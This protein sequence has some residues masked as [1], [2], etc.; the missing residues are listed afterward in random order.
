MAPIYPLLTV[1]GGDGSASNRDLLPRATVT[2]RHYYDA[3]L[4]L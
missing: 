4:L 1:K 2:M 3:P